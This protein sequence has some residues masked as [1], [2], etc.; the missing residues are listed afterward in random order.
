MICIGIEVDSDNLTL[1]VP[2][3]RVQELL[4]ELKHWSSPTTYTKEQLQSLPGKLS[5]VTAC[6]KPGRVFMSRLLHNLRS[7]PS[8]RVRHPVSHHMKADIAWWLSFLPV[9]N[10]FSLIKGTQSAMGQHWPGH[11][12]W[13]FEKRLPKPEIKSTRRIHLEIRCLVFHS[14]FDLL[15]EISFWANFYS[16]YYNIFS[17]LVKNSIQRNLKRRGEQR[18]GAGREKSPSFIKIT[19]EMNQ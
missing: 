9:F 16:S 4:D 17:C 5:F 12:F 10:G 13:Q 1:S 14:I 7:F 8:H 2:L 19:R 18:V 15:L 11:Y 6:M 3:S